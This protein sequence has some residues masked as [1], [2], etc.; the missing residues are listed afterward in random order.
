M[1]ERKYWRTPLDIEKARKQKGRV[2]IHEEWCK[3]CEFCS[4]FC[5]LD[6]LK[7]SE[8]FNSKGYHPV[9]VVDEESCVGCKLCECIC[10]EFAIIVECD[11]KEGR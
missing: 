10:P 4:F 9:E 1:G 6:V 11:V 3:G 2:I 7:M 8:R 5:P